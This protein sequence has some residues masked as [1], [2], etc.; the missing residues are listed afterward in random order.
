MGWKQFLKPDW[1]KIVLMLL[2]FLLGLLNVR[3]YT[4]GSCGVLQVITVWEERGLPFTFQVTKL[5]CSPIIFIL[6]PAFLDLIFWY[7]ISCLI[8]W[9][10]DRYRKK[11]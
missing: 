7:L 10:H 4:S 3:S 8:V 1:R 5:H 11:K 9:V 6:I 2:F